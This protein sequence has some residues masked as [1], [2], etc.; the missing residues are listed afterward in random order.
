MSG[1]ENTSSYRI[2][3]F[4]PNKTIKKHFSFPYEPKNS[5]KRELNLI[6]QEELKMKT[7]KALSNDITIG[8][9]S[10]SVAL[11]VLIIV[12]FV[13]YLLILTR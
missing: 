8:L 12:L 3:I 7:K 11:I 10:L 9:L 1:K 5:L 13:I 6:E 4:N 2:K